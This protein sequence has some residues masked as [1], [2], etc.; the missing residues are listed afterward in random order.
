MR[1][2]TCHDCVVTPPSPMKAIVKFSGRILFSSE[3][4]REMPA[5]IGMKNEARGDGGECPCANACVCM[6]FVIC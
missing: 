1:A 5:H 4:A 3:P 6:V 2:S